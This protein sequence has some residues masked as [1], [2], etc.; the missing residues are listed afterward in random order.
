LLAD[1]AH[2]IRSPQLYRIDEV[3]AVWAQVRAKV[4]HVEAAGSPT[5]TSLAGDLRGSGGQSSH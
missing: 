4:L 2:K 3:M 1:P 5:L